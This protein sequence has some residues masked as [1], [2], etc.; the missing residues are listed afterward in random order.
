MTVSSLLDG[1]KLLSLVPGVDSGASP[2]LVGTLAVM[3]ATL[4]YLILSA[5]M[6]RPSDS[7]AGTAQEPPLIPSRIPWFGHLLRLIQ[8][9]HG[10]HRVMLA[11]NGGSAPDIGSLRMLPWSKGA[12]YVVYKPT[13][14]QAALK[15][16]S[17]SFEPY[18]STFIARMTS[19]SARTMEIFDGPEFHPAWLKIIYS[20]MTGTELLRVNRT[21]LGVEL[22]VLNDTVPTTDGKGG[23]GTL[24]VPDLYA[25][26]KNLMSTATTTAL[27]G[28][29]NPWTKEPGLI[30]AYW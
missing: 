17:L 27:F 18:V 13:L 22:G 14:V 5:S 24:D 16:R 8:H 4:V 29:G 20:T 11:E 10:H 1:R 6:S 25:W 9:H 7:A 15:A 21:A 30:D 3:V 12:L 26:V 19:C 28:D 23:P 2:V